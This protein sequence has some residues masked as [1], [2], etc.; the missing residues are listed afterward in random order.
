MLTC[1]S[2]INDGL[3]YVT[4]CGG[5]FEGIELPDLEFGES[6]DCKGSLPA[7]YRAGCARGWESMYETFLQGNLVP[8]WAMAG[9]EALED[10]FVKDTIPSWAIAGWDA[11]RRVL[12]RHRAWVDS[13]HG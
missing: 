9:W 8:G 1:L 6:L 13:R 5:R 10:F 2:G 3:G 12:H 11:V 7:P 4:A